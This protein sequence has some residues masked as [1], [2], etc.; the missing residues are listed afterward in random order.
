M[1]IKSIQA[2]TGFSYSTISRVVNGKAKEYRI[3][4][5]TCNK[6]LEAAE[7]LN[8][9]PNIL[10]RGLRLK[11]TMT[12]G[13]IVSDIQNPF[14]GELGSGIERELRSHGYST[15]LCNANEV[16]E[17]E[18]FYLR[19]LVDRNVD[20]IIIVPVQAGEWSYLETLGKTTPV[21]LMDRTVHHTELP[22]VTS[23]NALAAEAMTDRLIAAGHVRIAYL[24]G[25]PLSYITEVRF[26]GFRRS[27]MRHGVPLDPGLVFSAGYSIK[28]GEEM[29]TEA[30]KREPGLRAAFCVN[31]LVF[32]GAMRVVQE[33][34]TKGAPGILMAAF[35][36]RAYCDIIK[37]PLVCANQD[38]ETIALTAVNLILDRIDGRP[39]QESHVVVPIKVAT[40][41]LPAADA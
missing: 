13:L 27:L 9:R 37:R 35:D 12:I 30:L 19:V 22:W 33:A 20:G 31:N 21:V 15:I 7:R 36:I 1:T 32:Q 17:N 25:T 3:S 14:F 34:E 28:S 5:E 39:R 40:H 41:R 38:V 29:M 4:E 16:A 24:G 18:E 23:E 6:I 11:K 10:A 26:T 8:Y 2:L